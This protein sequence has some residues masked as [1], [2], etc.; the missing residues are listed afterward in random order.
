MHIFVASCVHVCHMYLKYT[1]KWK[2]LDALRTEK[3]GKCCMTPLLYCNKEDVSIEI[4]T[5]GNS[6]AYSGSMFITSR[7]SSPFSCTWMM[8]KP[9]EGKHK[10]LVRDTACNDWNDTSN[11]GLLE[12]GIFY[13]G[14][15]DEK[16]RCHNRGCGQCKTIVHKDKEES[17][18]EILNHE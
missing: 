10:E 2:V 7:T 13:V 4:G 16:V 11:S 3:P 17:A 18:G 5:P 1:R 12:P 8:E 15:K 14:Q 6:E 9:F